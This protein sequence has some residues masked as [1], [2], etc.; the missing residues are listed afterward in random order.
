MDK[1]DRL[2]DKVGSTR[3]VYEDS[4]LDGKFSYGY[5]NL[6]AG[7]LQFVTRPPFQVRHRIHSVNVNGNT[8]PLL[9]FEVAVWGDGFNASSRQLMSQKVRH[10]C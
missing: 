4:L 2:G 3:V 9:T 1:G 8:L 10:P 7:T 6:P 5:D